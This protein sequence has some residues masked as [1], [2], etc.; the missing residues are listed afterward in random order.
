M[1]CFETKACSESP[2]HRFSRHAELVS[3]S[4]LM[5]ILYRI[6]PFSATFPFFLCDL[7]GKFFYQPVRSLNSHFKI[8]NSKYR[9]PFPNFQTSPFNPLPLI[10][11]GPPSGSRT[12]SRARTSGNTPLREACARARPSR[13][14][15]AA[16]ALHPPLGI[17]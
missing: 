15:P 14:R 17:A 10:A 5:I 13:P 3:A 8:Q 12:P 9:C 16:R 2:H 4:L 6:S 1:L 7:C 11:A